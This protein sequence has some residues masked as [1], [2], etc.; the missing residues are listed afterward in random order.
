VAEI[1]ICGDNGRVDQTGQEGGMWPGWGE[2]DEELS[3]SGDDKESNWEADTVDGETTQP[4]F[5]VVA[6]SFEDEVLVTEECHGDADGCRDG[7]SEVIHQPLRL[8][9]HEVLKDFSANVVDDKCE[10]SVPA[11]DDEIAH[12][13]TFG[14]HLAQCGEGAVGRGLGGSDGGRWSGSVRQSFH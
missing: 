4:L 3:C 10:D 13:L 9:R 14:D 11:T 8:G 7:V 5:Q 2:H 6:M 1:A 12:D